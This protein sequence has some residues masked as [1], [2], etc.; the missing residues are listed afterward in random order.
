MNFVELLKRSFALWWRVKILWLLGMLA[1]L[2]GYGD[3]PVNGNLNFSQNV[4]SDAGELPPWAEDLAANPLVRAI[5]DNPLPFIV[6]VV[7]FVILV[8]LVTALIG[9]LAHGAMIRV[10]DVADQGYRATLGDGFRVG[11]ARALPIFLL[12]LLLALPVIAVVAVLVLIGA[13]TLGGL[14][15]TAE[16]GG[17]GLDVGPFIASIFGLVLCVLAM[18]V[19]LW[20][21]GALLGIWS[22]LAQRVCVIEVRGPVAS[23]GRAWGL[24]RRNL[25]LTLLTWL[26]QAILGGLIGVV[27]ALPALALA[28]P[29]IMAITRGDAFPVGLIVALILY[30]I[31]ASTLVGGLLTAFNSAMWTVIYR[32]F[33]ARDQPYESYA[34]A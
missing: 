15:A 28:F 7:V 3:A 23:L 31:A 22:R 18:I 34:A 13:F 16:T 17:S 21:V 8:S 1:A 9:A 26:F 6:G 12:N 2:V 4:S 29:A 19:V 24:I 20:V 27:L 10:A 5:A 11:L 25:G 30:A 33:V 32:A 14:I